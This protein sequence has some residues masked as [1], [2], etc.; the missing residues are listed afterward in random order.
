MSG[1]PELGF[2][3]SM[4]GDR[5][6]NL[7]VRVGLL[8]HKAKFQ[9][10]QTTPEENSVRSPGFEIGVGSDLAIGD[11]LAIVPAVRLY[12]YNSGWDLG[13][14]GAKRIKKNIGWIQPDLGL[15]LRLGGAR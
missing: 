6:F 1:G 13:T 7:W 12:R 14:P 2:K 15:Q 8:A 3:F 4:V 5:S 11:V 10:G 9:E